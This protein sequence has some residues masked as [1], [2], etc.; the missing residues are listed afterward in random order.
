MDSIP[1]FKIALFII[2]LFIIAD[3]STILP[4]K[5]FNVDNYGARADGSTDDKFF[6]LS[7]HLFW[8]LLPKAFLR[9]WNDA[10]Q[11]RGR[12]KVLIPLGNY[13]LNSVTFVGPCNG[14]MIFVIKG[15]LRAPTNPALF[16]TNTWI[17]FRY[18][19]NLT[20]EGGGYLDGQGAAAWPHNDCSKN[21][22][23]LPLP[24]SL[25]LDFITNSRIQKLRSIN[26]KN[27]H[28]NLFACNNINISHVRLSA[29]GNSPN[30]DGIHIGFSNNIKISSVNIGT[31]DDCISMVSGS[32]NIVISDVFCG[33]GHGI[34]IGSLG[35]AFAKEYVMHINV[36]NTTFRNTQNGVRIKTWSPSSPS[37]ASDINF[38][39]IIMDN[40]NNPIIIDQDYCPF[41][42]PTGGESISQVQIR[43]VT[44]RNISGTSSSKVAIY[45]QCSRVVPCHK[46]K[47]VDID[48][49]YR[50]AGG[51]AIASCS[52]VYGASYGKQ[53]PSGCL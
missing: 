7:I 40:V 32:Q 31:G 41:C 28:V 12:S 44:F 42:S 15:T 30:T 14:E 20:L 33:P 4:P 36:V 6:T 46:V 2:F 53:V 5:I 35:R 1:A 17:G 10:C 16:F 38:Q 52:N 21:I 23:C 22:G 45:L 19:D 13:M 25:R 18:V 47:L 34:S 39:D 11:W 3:A 27:A 50:E 24:I 49:A 37:L 43:D 51:P 9:A 48:L 8:L 29:P 26:S